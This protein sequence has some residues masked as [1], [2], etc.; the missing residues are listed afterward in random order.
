MS[1]FGKD[2]DECH[3]QFATTS[4]SWIDEG[5][6]YLHQKVGMCV[7]EATAVDDSEEDEEEQL[8]LAQHEGETI[9]Q[10]RKI[11]RR[12]KSL[13]LVLLF[14]GSATAFFMWAMAMNRGVR[15]NTVQFHNATITTSSKGKVSMQVSPSRMVQKLGWI[16]T[17]QYFQEQLGQE[18]KKLN[19]RWHDAILSEPRSKT[20]EIE[21]LCTLIDFALDTLGVRGVILE[22]F[23]YNLAKY[24]IKDDAFEKKEKSLCNKATNKHHGVGCGMHT[25][26]W[27]DHYVGATMADELVRDGK[28]LLDGS[29]NSRDKKNYV[30][31]SVEFMTEL[32]R[33]QERVYLPNDHS[34]HMSHGFVWQYVL[35]TQPD[36]QSYPVELAS[37][38]CSKY[39]GSHRKTGKGSAIKS[40]GAECY[41][42]FG[43]AVFALVASRQEAK[44]GT[45]L[46]S[47]RTQ[48]TPM[49][50]FQLSDEAICEAC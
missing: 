28:L 24:H 48:F 18:S 42:S 43:H 47:A 30:H 1:P 29:I 46:V 5:D 35:M 41:H 45:K 39:L 12:L 19:R 7:D 14:S 8:L 6:H 21:S 15:L 49:S 33:L 13:A 22:L 4:S 36:L 26:W 32:H 20:M 10:S 31:S 3:V 38:F 11:A 9:A 25:I 37:Q 34:F 2:E 23:S 27:L 17:V 40:I 16:E 44:E 50:G